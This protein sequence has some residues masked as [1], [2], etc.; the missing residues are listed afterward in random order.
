MGDVLLG[1][2]GGNEGRGAPGE[3]WDSTVCVRRR[4]WSLRTVKG[5]AGLAVLGIA[6]AENYILGYVV[7]SV[8]INNSGLNPPKSL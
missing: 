4:N 1:G 2:E 7:H 6:E 8:D 3:A 5:T